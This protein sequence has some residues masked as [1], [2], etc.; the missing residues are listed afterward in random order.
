MDNTGSFKLGNK[1]K[2]TN[3]KLIWQ[4]KLLKKVDKIK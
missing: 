3:Q 1:T 2:Q 4:S